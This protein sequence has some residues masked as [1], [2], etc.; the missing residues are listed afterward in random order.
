MEKLYIHGTWVGTVLLVHAILGL[1]AFEWAWKSTYRYRNP[2]LELDER[3]PA[4]RRTDAMKWNKCH[5][6]FGAM[7]L[8][9]PRLIAIVWNVLFLT[10]AVKILLCG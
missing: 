1:I 7:T 5:F 3:F 2:I 6:Y 9:V 8:L 4:Y 10:L